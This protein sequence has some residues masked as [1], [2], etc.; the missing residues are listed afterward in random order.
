MKNIVKKSGVVFLSAVLLAGC[1]SRLTPENYSKVQN[2]QTEAE[3]VNL[4]GKPTQMKSGSVL[5][6]TGTT[7]IYQ[8]KGK[9]VKV[10]F[11]NGKVIAKE[12]TL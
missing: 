11:V 6:I 4:I 3:V 12:G 8:E 10:I 9:E 5:G 2:D 1:G 7:Y